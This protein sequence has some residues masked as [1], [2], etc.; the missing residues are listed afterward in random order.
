MLNIS[1]PDKAKAVYS[2]SRQL[3][4]QY[5]RKRQDVE[6]S[7]LKALYKPFEAFNKEKYKE[8]I[9][10]TE[11]MLD[12]EA[13]DPG[14]YDKL[15][16]L[17][18]EITDLSLFGLDYYQNYYQN[19]LLVLVTLSFMGWIMCLVKT[20]LEQKI[21]NQSE[22]SS[23]LKKYSYRNRRHILGYLSISN[24]LFST[25]SFIAVFLVFGKHYKNIFI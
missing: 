6:N 22:S 7:A 18:E 13:I 3:A 5:D 11:K 20:L 2:N 25:L 12:N 17:S 14:E 23:S 19:P 16:L 4:S 24:M 15:I 21:N 10:F 9:E 8:A 1:L